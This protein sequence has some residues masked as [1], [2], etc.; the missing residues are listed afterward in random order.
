MARHHTLLASPLMTTLL[1]LLLTAEKLKLEPAQ[2]EALRKASKAM[3]AASVANDAKA[4]VDTFYPGAVKAMGGAE[5]ALKTTA[6]SME[7]SKNNP[8][9]LV[10]ADAA[11][12]HFCTRGKDGSLQ[13]VLKQTNRYLH[14]GTRLVSTGDVVAF[15]PDKGATWTFL[16]A[17]LQALDRLRKTFPELS[18]DLPISLQ[19]PPAPER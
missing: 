1:F 17:S 14:D 5:E 11:D 8:I 13:C 7:R 19:K 4:L 15:S 6:E 3:C 16:N 2:L 9:K 10:S 12:P 18:P